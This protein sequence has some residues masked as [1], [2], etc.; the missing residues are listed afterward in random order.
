METLLAPQ[1]QM[2]SNVISILLEQSEEKTVEEAFNDLLN[3]VA[4]N[5]SYETMIETP[6]L[7]KELLER[8]NETL[9]IDL[10]RKDQWDWF[11]EVYKLR[12][13]P[14]LYLVDRNHVEDFVNQNPLK[15]KNNIY[16][17]LD[18]VAGSGRLVLEYNR[19]A[20][21]NTS[22]VYYGAEP[23]LVAY[24]MALLNCAI[25]GINS[26]ILYINSEEYDVRSKS[27]N[28]KFA[29]KWTPVK[30]GKFFTEEQMNQL[31]LKPMQDPPSVLYYD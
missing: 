30:K 27:V 29:N 8:I 26:R 28:W 16:T 24:R 21:P 14:E 2:L 25:Y 15:Y 22:I 13:K 4:Y 7:K 6:W 12:L 20:P 23:N 11:G 19:I 17:L 9:D 10:L 18:N 1:T 5:I 3:I 31:E